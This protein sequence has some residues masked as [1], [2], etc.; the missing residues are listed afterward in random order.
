M[1]TPSCINPIIKP[2]M[3]QYEAGLDEI[4]GARFVDVAIEPARPNPDTPIKPAKPTPTTPGK[5]TNPI[6]P[7]NPGVPTID[8]SEKDCSEPPKNIEKLE[9]NYEQREHE[10]MYGSDD[11]DEVVYCVCGQHY[12]RKSMCMYRVFLD[13]D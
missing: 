9:T 2:F 1:A 13:S 11:E 5:P 10:L 8:S 7:T 4:F 3:Q 6:N 12:R